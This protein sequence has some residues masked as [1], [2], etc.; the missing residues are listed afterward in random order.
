MGS[1]P[2]LYNESL[3]VARVIRVLELE[4]WIEFWRVGI[5]R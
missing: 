1:D 3:F 4:N 2:R 5:P